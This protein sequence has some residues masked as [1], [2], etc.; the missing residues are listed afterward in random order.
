MRAPE[1]PITAHCGRELPALRS[2]GGKVPL[3]PRQTSV[4]GTKRKAIL[5]GPAILSFDRCALVKALRYILCQS[6]R[7]RVGAFRSILGDQGIAIE[8][9][10][11]IFWLSCCRFDGHR[12]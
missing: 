7:L 2:I 4:G 6:D 9:E 5:E 11:E 1:E 8:H 12:D 3:K 10:R